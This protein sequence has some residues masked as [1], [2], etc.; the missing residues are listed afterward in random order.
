MR[1]G[2]TVVL[3]QCHHH[4]PCAE[5]RVHSGT[6]LPENGVQVSQRAIVVVVIVVAPTA[7]PA[8]AFLEADLGFFAAL[9]ATASHC[10]DRRHIVGTRPCWGQARPTHTSQREQKKRG[11]GK[12]N[13]KDTAHSRVRAVKISLCDSA[14]RFGFR[15]ELRAKVKKPTAQG[16]LY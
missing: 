12:N 10:S 13:Q 5:L 15:F 3:E 11:A 16:V 4:R 14:G 1:H 8:T 6:V 9:Q 2:K 7:G